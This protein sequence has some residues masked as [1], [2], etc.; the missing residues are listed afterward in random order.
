MI[1]TPPPAAPTSEERSLAALAHLF[2]WLIALI[3]FLTQRQRSA[4]V[5]FQAAQALAFH[6]ATM[7]LWALLMIVF[8]ALVF[9]LAGAALTAGLEMAPA[10]PQSEDQ[11]LTG[12]F[13]L[14]QGLA[15]ALAGGGICLSSISLALV[16]VRAYAAAQA[17][18]GSAFRYPWLGDRLEKWLGTEL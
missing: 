13:L 15:L 14:G 8:L 7:A 1:E 16:I 12:L 4:Y 11:W 18:R 10:V 9:G 5:R 6:A 17:L 3:I 2:G